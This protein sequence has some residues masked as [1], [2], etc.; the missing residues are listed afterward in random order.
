MKFEDALG[1]LETLIEK[2]ESEDLSLDDLVGAYERG[3]DLW[4][5]CQAR[6]EQARLKVEAIS[7]KATEESLEIEDF[8]S[9]GQPAAAA[10]KPAEPKSEDVSDDEIKLF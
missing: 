7:K 2:M 9:T 5:T 3:T 1:E 4:K 10:K 6:L 8:E